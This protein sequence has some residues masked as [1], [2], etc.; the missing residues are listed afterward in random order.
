MLGGGAVASGGLGMAGGTVVVTATGSALGGALG[1]ATVSAYAGDDPSFSIELVREGVGSPV[2][3][4]TGFLTQGRSAWDQ[5]RRLVDERYPD[6]PVYQVHWGAKE[7]RDLTGLLVSNGGKAAVRAVLVQGAKRGS[8][9]FG[10]P[11]IGWVLGAHSV[12]TNPWTVAKTR[13]GMTGA[14]LAG[15]LSRTLEGPY[16]LMGHSLGARVMVTAARTLATQSGPPR[17]ESMHLLGAAVGRK[18]D[19]RSLEE[20]V[21][22][23]VWNYWSANDNVLRWLYALAERGEKPVG[24]EGFQSKFS[25]IKDRNVSRHVSDHSAYVSKVRLQA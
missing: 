17:V 7:L 23:T 5:W 14:A 20:A 18:G 6:A 22:G 13:A 2:V 16:V 4:A 3:F 21:N 8:K 1:A 10:L 19:W 9:A 24:H 11:G 15:L 12:A 25:R